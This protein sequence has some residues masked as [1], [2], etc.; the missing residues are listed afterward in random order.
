VISDI[1][2]CGFLFRFYRFFWGRLNLATVS[3]L[4]LASDGTMVSLF[5]FVKSILQ[6][7]NI[8]LYGLAFI[9]ALFAVF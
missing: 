4:S 3:F 5:I 9:I 7:K 1:S 2:L 8:V 6:T